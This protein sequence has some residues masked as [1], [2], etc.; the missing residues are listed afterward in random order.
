MANRYFG[1]APLG[2]PQP[3]RASPPSPSQASLPPAA[4]IAQRLA[5]RQPV[6]ASSF[7]APTSNREALTFS[8]RFPIETVLQAGGMNGA[9]IMATNLN[10]APIAIDP[11]A[12][13]GSLG[14]MNMDTSVS[15][16]HRAQQ[17]LG[18]LIDAGVPVS[19]DYTDAIRNAAGFAFGPKRLPKQG[20]SA[21]SYSYPAKQMVVGATLA[22]NPI[23]N[24][25]PTR[26]SSPNAPKFVTRGGGQG[27]RGQISSSPSEDRRRLIS[28]LMGLSA[29][30]YSGIDYTRI[31]TGAFGI[32]ADKEDGVV[33]TNEQTCR[34]VKVIRV[35][36]A[37]A[38]AGKPVTDDAIMFYGASKWN[39]ISTLTGVI[40]Q[41]WNDRFLQNK[42]LNDDNYASGF[43]KWAND[44]VTSKQSEAEEAAKKKAQELADKAGGGGGG[45]GSTQ[46][47]IVFKPVIPGFTV[48]TP[49]GGAPA[50]QQPAAGGLSPVTIGVGVAALAAVAFIAT[51][52]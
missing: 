9:P 4:P 45:G 27:P 20:Y 32:G 39:S 51:R 26:A 1:Q 17:A 24:P 30:D 15:A 43:A 41:T 7:I 3:V 52:K 8:K 16:R 12:R 21:A 2:I 49:G 42:R 11:M 35:R 6:R 25:Q 44:F 36:K 29:I 18:A 37:L 5:N 50:P 34:D 33:C 19:G 31:S 14:F 23:I 46:P 47:P 48:I 22:G 28:T 38:A 13:P 10:G 40:Q